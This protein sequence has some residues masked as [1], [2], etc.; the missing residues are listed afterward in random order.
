MEKL[1]SA[2]NW[3]EGGYRAN[4]VTY[5]IAKVVYD[6]VES[7]PIVDLDR[8]WLT[9]DVPEALENALMVAG[10]EAQTIILDPQAVRNIGE[11]AK[12]QACWKILTDIELHNPPANIIFSLLLLSFNLISSSI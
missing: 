8:I 3:Y 5:G 1:V 11:W 9:Q 7:G 6:T 2:S 10:A 12:K 4:I